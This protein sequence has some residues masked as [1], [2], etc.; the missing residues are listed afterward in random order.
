MLHEI[1][2]KQ[3][4]KSATM[5]GMAVTV[6]TAPHAIQF[7]DKGFER[8]RGGERERGRGRRKEAGWV[9]EG[10]Q[11]KKSCDSKMHA[12]YLGRKGERVV[13]RLLSASARRGVGFVATRLAMD[14]DGRVGRR[15]SSVQAGGCGLT[16]G[17]AVLL[18][19][20]HGE[21]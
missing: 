20:W 10:V 14:E 21:Q 1:G 3:K 2:Q 8:K 13:R 19:P 6:A 12:W 18:V 9:P 15:H 4:R 17:P 7:H 16:R 11:T 5:A